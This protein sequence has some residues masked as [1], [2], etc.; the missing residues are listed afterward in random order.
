MVGRRTCDLGVAGSSAGRDAA[1]QQPQAS[2]S[3]PTASVTKQYN[4]VPAKVGSLTGTPRDALA[5][6]PWSCRFIW[7][8][9]EATETEIS[10]A[11]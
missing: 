1:A 11:L 5:P 3:Q 8:L 9:A 6:C 10:A 4:L 7:C 2:C